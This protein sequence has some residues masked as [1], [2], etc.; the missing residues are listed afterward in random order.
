MGTMTLGAVNIYHTMGFSE[1]CTK[2]LKN[3]RPESTGSVNIS[4]FS[5]P[6]NS[7]ILFNI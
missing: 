7:S 6:V 2:E 3:R 1:A 5:F 4:C